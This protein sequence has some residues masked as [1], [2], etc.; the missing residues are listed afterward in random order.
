MKEPTIDLY[1]NIKSILDRSK[2]YAVKQVNHSLVLAYWTI[3]KLI[4]ENMIEGDRAEY[5]KKI[6]QQLSEKLILEYGSGFSSANLSRMASFYCYFKDK[7]IVATL[8]QQFTWS[9]FVELIKIKD[10]MK[11]EFY[12]TMCLNEKWSIRVL[13]ER[14][15]SL[16]F[17]RTAIS[18]KPEETIKSDLHLLRTEN[19]MSTSLFLRDPYFLDFLDLK[20]QFNEKDLEN[21]I[22]LCSGKDK[23]IIELMDLEKDNI[24]IS[25][26][27]LQLPPKEILQQKLSNAI[28][29]A[30]ARIEKKL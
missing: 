24:H 18:K 28:E 12:V 22:I 4:K 13:R 29:L 17:E 3:G 30:K 26:Y 9:H 6:L 10:E 15:N 5:G 23:D 25:E 21:A 20:D 2:L 27:W 16:L 19:K 14:I 8:S 1:S 7:E 11:R